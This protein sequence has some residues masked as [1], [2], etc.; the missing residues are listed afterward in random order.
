[1]GMGKQC[2]LGAETLTLHGPQPPSRHPRATT[3][4]YGNV[5]GEGG[6]MALERST[7]VANSRMPS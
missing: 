6:V 5:G 4:Y 3:L 1:M 2:L 7:A